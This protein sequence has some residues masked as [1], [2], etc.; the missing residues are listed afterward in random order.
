MSSIVIKLS[1]AVCVVLGWRAELCRDA[2]SGG[3]DGI[4]YRRVHRGR[5]NPQNLSYDGGVVSWGGQEE[6]LGRV[7]WR[8]ASV[9][10][11]G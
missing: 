1:P 11:E 8:P 10:R 5:W 7:L 9:L 3:I 6:G 2:V 4:D